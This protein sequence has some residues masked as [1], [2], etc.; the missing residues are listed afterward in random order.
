MHSRLWA[1]KPTI[2]DT[3]DPSP[4]HNQS[5]FKDGMTTITM[6][7]RYHYVFLGM[8]NISTI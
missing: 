2:L 3:T 8:E 5:G 7:Y 6:G 1:S 4:L